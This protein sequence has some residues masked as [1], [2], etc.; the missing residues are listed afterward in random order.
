MCVCA[1]A[2]VCLLVFYFFVTGNGHGFACMFVYACAR[3]LRVALSR[4]NEGL[5]CAWNSRA[6]FWKKG[7]Q[8]LFD[9]SPSSFMCCQSAGLRWPV[10]LCDG[11]D[12][13]KYDGHKTVL[14]QQPQGL[15]HNNFTVCLCLCTLVSAGVVFF[16]FVSLYLAQCPRVCMFTHTHLSLLLQ[17]HGSLSG[18]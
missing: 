15:K 13:Q 10:R 5:R 14:T 3:H 16:V 2:L 17:P 7:P 9:V 12:G 6:W 1:C 4:E 18:S 11:F 8:H